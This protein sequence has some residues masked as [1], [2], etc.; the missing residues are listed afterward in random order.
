MEEVLGGGVWNLRIAVICPQTHFV[1]SCE[2]KNTILW[3]RILEVHL[4]RF[5]TQKSWTEQFTT[6][7][8]LE[9]GA[10][11]EQTWVECRR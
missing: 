7:H 5:E 8:V 3:A 11:L 2:K 10:V 6:S 1:T 9:Q 4:F